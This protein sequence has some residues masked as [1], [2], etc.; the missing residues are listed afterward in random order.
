M[1]IKVQFIL[2]WKHL[3][4]DFHQNI[5][6]YQM[7]NIIVFIVK[8]AFR[9]NEWHLTYFEIKNIQYKWQWLEL[10]FHFFL[11]LFLSHSLSGHFLWNFVLLSCSRLPVTVPL[12]QLCCGTYILLLYLGKC[13]Y[14]IYE[15]LS[16]D[17]KE[18][19]CSQIRI[20]NI[21]WERGG[22]KVRDEFMWL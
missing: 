6:N 18:W 22:N 5:D 1:K 11:F 16:R 7:K 21:E 12:I 15:S 9:A 2:L 14:G 10:S 17:Q 3:G 13:L 20:L 8:F 4:I 19:K